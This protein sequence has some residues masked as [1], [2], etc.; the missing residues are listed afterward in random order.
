MKDENAKLK[1]ALIELSRYFTSGNEF[2][3]ER[4]TI[5]AKDFWKIVDPVLIVKKV[6]T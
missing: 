4:A 6:N 3:V 5:L 2:P 1:A